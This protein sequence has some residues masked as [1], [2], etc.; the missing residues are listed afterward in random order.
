M[1]PPTDSPSASPSGHLS[2]SLNLSL[3]PRW[4]FAA[5]PLSARL[6]VSSLLLASTLTASATSAAPALSSTR[7]LFA[8]LLG[9]SSAATAQKIDAGYRQLFHGRDDDQR[10]YFPVGPDMAYI[11]D[12]GS[13]DVR[14]EGMSY[15]LMIAVQTDHRAE[16]D[17]LW[18]WAKT[19]MYHASGP[20]QG[21]F[22]WHCAFDGRQLDPGSASDGEEWF[23]TA[24]FFASHR[25]GDR[26]GIYN[27]RAEAQA[28]LRAM[29][30]QPS[31]DNVTAIFDRERQLVVF[32]PTGEASQFT[33]PSYHLPAFYELWARWADD[34]ADRA[35]WAAAARASRQYLHLAAH[36]QTGLMPEYAEFDGRPHPGG[37]E[38]RFDAWRTPANVAL[39]HAWWAAAPWQPS[40]SNRVLRFFGRL[41]PRLPNQFTLDGQPLS[42]DVST[43]LIA[44]AAVAGLAGDADLA[45]PFVQQLWDAPVPSGHW[46]YY[47]GLL[48]ELALLQAGGRFQIF[49][50]ADAKPK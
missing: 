14:T 32:A 10:L 37:A 46:R 30:H 8:E 19:Y 16:F 23:A 5:F 18:K 21:F 33:D 48:Y 1:N 4:L 24:L 44:M 22:A 17:R 13:N 27:Y 47:D 29:L 25:W 15:G 20:R 49:W 2:L 6:F 9:Q 3:S 36:P 7:N 12:V 34:P 38:F 28:L 35:F 31:V 43:G 50:P 40:Q 45:R 42:T 39:D 11:A 41:A 26:T